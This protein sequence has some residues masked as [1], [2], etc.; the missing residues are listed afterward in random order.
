VTGQILG[1]L[2]MVLATIELA[3]R[4]HEIPHHRELLRAGSHEPG[5][6]SELT[7]VAD[8]EAELPQAR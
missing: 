3:R 4:N 5:A 1:F 7:A 6:R 8:L 2:V